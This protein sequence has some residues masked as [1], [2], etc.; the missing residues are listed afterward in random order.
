MGKFLKILASLLV[1]VFIV[2]ALLAWWY[3]RWDELPPPQLPGVVERG[4]LEYDGRRREWLAYIPEAIDEKPA[5]LLLL[6]GSKHSGEQ[7]RTGSFYSFDYLAEQKGFIAVYPS[8]FEGH[9]NDCRASAGFSANTLDIDDVG[10]LRALAGTLVSLYG[11]DPNRIYAAG[12]SNGGHMAYRLGFEAPD[13]V[14]GIGAIAANLP[15]EGNFAC[16]A[17]GEAVATIII[18]GTG[19]PVNPYQG[20]IVDLFG[21]T[22]R[23]AVQS[24]GASVAYW[25]E[26]AGYSADPEVHKWPDRD[27]GDGTSVRSERWQGAGKPPVQLVT[28]EGG[29]HGIPHPDYSGPRI[30]GRPSHEFNTAQILWAF[31]E[32]I[33]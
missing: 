22:S 27:P 23:G 30:L 28:V 19:D 14:K 5:L 17:S 33:D 10:F 32:S 9:W 11:A 29:G 13:L 26:L 7:M 24:A 3:L 31:F 15:V 1:L 16:E 2:I 21:D 12:V 25:A 6:R 4:T 20:G 8:G 18:N